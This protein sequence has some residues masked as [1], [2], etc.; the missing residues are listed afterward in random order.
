MISLYSSQDDA[1]SNHLTVCCS[2]INAGML[3]T[4]FFLG[5]YMTMQ[6]YC[7][8]GLSDVQNIALVAQFITQFAMMCAFILDAI[9]RDDLASGNPDS[10]VTRQLLVQI[11]IWIVNAAVILRLIYVL[12]F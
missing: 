3:I 11:M 10:T 1:Y 12:F 7:T 6:P 4:F 9:K 8:R 5:M 2:Y